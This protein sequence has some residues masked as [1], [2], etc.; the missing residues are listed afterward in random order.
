LKR[1][2]TELPFN[3]HV[4]IEAAGDA[5]QLLRLPPGGQYLN[6]L[7]SVHASALLALA[8]ASSGEF[9][10][11][12]FGSAEGVIPV[13][14]RM[15]AK[16]RKP[17]HGGV[18][19]TASAAADALTQLDADLAAKGRTLISIAVEL[20]DDSGAHALSASVEWF[21][22]RLAPEGQGLTAPLSRHS[23]GDE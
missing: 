7:G 8:E 4:G 19:S 20:H 1:S 23:S 6:H 10:L 12:H 5:P 11:R 14:R 16:F 15:E 2:V 18:A 17:A 3:I 21:I 22:Q 13:V 9:L